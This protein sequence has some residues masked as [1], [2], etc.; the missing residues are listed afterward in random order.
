MRRRTRVRVRNGLPIQRWTN[1]LSGRR[2]GLRS[3][4]CRPPGKPR[5]KIINHNIALT[6]AEWSKMRRARCLS[7]PQQSQPQQGTSHFAR[8]S[9]RRCNATADFFYLACPISLSSA[10][11]GA[12]LCLI[13]LLRRSP[14]DLQTPLRGPL[15]P[16]QRSCASSDRYTRAHSHLSPSAHGIIPFSAWFKCA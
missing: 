10:L 15:S 12:K 9:F 4:V 5:N 2:R 6:R 3:C 7:R 1:T 13:L 8:F 14:G 11:V 16:T